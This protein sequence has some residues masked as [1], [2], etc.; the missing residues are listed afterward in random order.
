MGEDRDADAEDIPEIVESD[1]EDEG[2]GNLQG[3]PYQYR[4]K[5][6][7]L[8]TD[9]W[10]TSVES[11]ALIIESGNHCIGTVKSN[12]TGDVRQYLETMFALD[13]YDM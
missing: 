5:N 3:F 2:H 7:V 9:N 4:N 8:A 12:R 11:S 1:G 13:Y 10:F 6:H